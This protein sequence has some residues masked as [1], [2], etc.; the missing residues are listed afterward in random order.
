MNGRRLHVWLALAPFLLV[1]VLAVR[2]FG[3]AFFDRRKLDNA[4]FEATKWGRAYGYDAAKVAE[5]ARA[6]T[7]LTGIAVSP[8]R[9]CGCSTGGAILQAE[10]NAACPGGGFSQPYIVVTTAMC[11]RPTL[12]WP[13]ISYCSEADSECVAAGCSS[14]QILLSAQSVTLQ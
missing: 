3:T 11:Y 5:V 10:C 2:D 13:A 14:T 8:L 1:L 4:A 7:K 9:P 12:S 6:A